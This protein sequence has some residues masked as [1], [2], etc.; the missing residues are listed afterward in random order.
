M[1]YAE[2]KNDED[3]ILLLA[4]NDIS[5]GQENTWYLDTSASNH[6]MSLSRCLLEFING[7]LKFANHILWVS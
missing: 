2:E 4:R 5:K 3:D 7:F 6:E 1:N